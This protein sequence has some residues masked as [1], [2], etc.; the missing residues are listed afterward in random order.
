MAD[1][2][3]FMYDS[4]TEILRNA[5]YSAYESGE[6]SDEDHVDAIKSLQGIPR[7]A[8]CPGRAFH[9]DPQHVCDPEGS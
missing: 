7:N 8:V 3:L 4:T 9:N 5:V 1:R 6:L 2:N